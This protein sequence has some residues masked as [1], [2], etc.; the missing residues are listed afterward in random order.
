MSVADYSLTFFVVLN[1]ARAIA[2]GPQIV[3]IYRDPG[4]ANAVSLW[5]WSIFTAANFATMIY[6][7]AALGA[8]IVAAVFGVNV[9]G[10]AAIVVLTTH[11]RCRRRWRAWKN[12]GAK[13]RLNQTAIQPGVNASPLPHPETGSPGIYAWTSKP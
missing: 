3:S 8:P 5:T 10:C 4:S 7:L 9:I 13:L 2:Y 1:L 12:I 6:A 11:K